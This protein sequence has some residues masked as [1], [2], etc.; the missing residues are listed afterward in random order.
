MERY[1]PRAVRNRQLEHHDNP[2]PSLP[3]WRRR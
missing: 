3:R 2:L 1:V